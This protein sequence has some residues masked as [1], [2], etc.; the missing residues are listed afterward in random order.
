[1]R[2]D[3]NKESENADRWLV[4]YADF[5]TLLFAFFVVMYSVSQVNEGKFK[6]LSETL[7]DAFVQPER[8]LQPIQVGEVNKADTATSG[9]N[10]YPNDYVEAETTEEIDESFQELR[11]SLDESLSELV[12]AGLVKIRS[13][14]NWIEINM[15][16]GLLFKSGEDTLSENANLTLKT[17]V[18]TMNLKER[19]HA[20]MI[21]GYTDNIPIKSRKFSSNWSLSSARA[22]SVLH[23]LEQAGI[24]SFLL[25]IEGYGQQQPEADNNTAVGRKANRRVV[26]AISRLPPR[27]SE[28]QLQ[29]LEEAEAQLANTTTTE[30]DTESE[31]TL[32]RAPDGSLIIRGSNDSVDNS[33]NTDNE[34]NNNQ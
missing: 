26:M 7:T 16:S 22:V 28:L 5:I 30:S 25:T 1:M 9:E 14:Q 10:T 4:S 11:A 12:D 19:Q 32:I 15:G 21:R 13:N 2:H 33:T 31:I 3:F 17:I 18:D 8:S 23:K 20:I 29:A 27:K 6:I 34:N 24:P